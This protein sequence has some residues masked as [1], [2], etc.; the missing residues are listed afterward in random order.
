MRT[1]HGKRIVRRK[2]VDLA[3]SPHHYPTIPKTTKIHISS[4]PLEGIARLSARFEAISNG[5]GLSKL[6]NN[7]RKTDGEQTF[8]KTVMAGLWQLTDVMTWSMLTV[9]FGDISERLRE[10]RDR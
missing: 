8:T 3:I 9:W 4:E 2:S 7:A 10:M 5:I 1:H 6:H